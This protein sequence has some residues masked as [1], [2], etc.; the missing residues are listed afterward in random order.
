M[1][2][3]HKPLDGKVAIVSGAA[4][5]IGLGRAMTLAL[6][7]AVSAGVAFLVSMAPVLILH[8]LSPD[9]ALRAGS[10][11]VTAAPR[12]E[13][14]LKGLIALEMTLSFVLL[15]G[16]G[17]FLGSYSRLRQVSPGFDPHGVLL[18]PVTAG[19]EM[20]PCAWRKVEIVP[21]STSGF[22]TSG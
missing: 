1:S 22:C 5:S 15:F 17:L 3:Q 14:V 16:A 9:A 12:T 19:G 7:L 21:N 11:S 6:V 20:K 2:M 10:K 4:S 8:R 18:A 13:R